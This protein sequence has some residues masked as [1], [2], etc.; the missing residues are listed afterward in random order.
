VCVCSCRQ[1]ETDAAFLKR[2]VRAG[3][4]VVRGACAGVDPRLVYTSVKAAT[5]TGTYWTR[6]Q[7]ETGYLNGEILNAKPGNK[8]YAGACKI[9]RSFVWQTVL[10]IAF[11]IAPFVENWDRGFVNIRRPVDPMTGQQHGLQKRHQDDRVS[12]LILSFRFT[13]SG[14]GS[15]GCINYYLGDEEVTVDMA[16]GDV[17]VYLHDTTHPPGTTSSMRSPRTPRRTSPR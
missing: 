1:G 13:F 3:M 5:D 15:A 4:T 12:S 11:L 17:G 6:R 9:R 7:G 2:Q 8:D 16:Y 14:A 10:K